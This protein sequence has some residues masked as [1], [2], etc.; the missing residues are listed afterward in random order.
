MI[1]HYVVF[2]LAV[3]L[4]V[5]VVSLLMEVVFLSLRREGM[6]ERDTY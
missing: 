6:M 2:N 5:N 4:I 1:F 3:L